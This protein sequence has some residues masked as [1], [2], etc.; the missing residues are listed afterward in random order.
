MGEGDEVTLE[1]AVPPPPPPGWTRDFLFK[2][3]GWDKD[4]NLATAAG[5]AVEPL[6]FRSMRSY[7]P[8]PDDP[9]PDSAASRSWLR[10]RQ[11]R[12]QTGAFWRAVR[13][14]TVSTPGGG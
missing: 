6:P 3:V 12:R 2:S 11:T 10:D 8:G 9:P 13:D 4:A 1:F 14:G 7:P 5:Q